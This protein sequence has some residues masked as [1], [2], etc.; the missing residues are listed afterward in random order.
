MSPFWS[1]V[2]RWLEA[3]V[4]TYKFDGVRRKGGL[5]AWDSEI[6]KEGT[7]LFTDQLNSTELC[8]AI[9]NL[10]NPFGGTNGGLALNYTYENLFAV[11]SDPTVTR[12]IIFISDG[13]SQ[14]PLAGPA[15]RV[16]T[17]HSLT[18]RSTS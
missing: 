17:G 2:K 3:L 18:G 12:E 16:R 6:Y 5:V 15:Q 4:D 14:T 10:P 8:E 11:G 13:E 1:L 7:V 9:Q